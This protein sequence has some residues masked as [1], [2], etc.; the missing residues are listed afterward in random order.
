M[1]RKLDQIL[2]VDVESSCWE[3]SP[4][5]GEESE[6]IEIGICVVDT[7]QLQ[8]ISKHSILVRPEKS[9]VS[10]FCTELTTLTPGMFA[11]A[12]TLR[13]SDIVW[14]DAI[15]VMEDKHRSRIRAD[16]PGETKFVTVHGLR[17]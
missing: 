10:D 3:G 14:A 16:F 9:T 7:R 2:V 8:R 17:P 5:E 1:A 6:I 11:E 15:L 13:S 4:P 12:E